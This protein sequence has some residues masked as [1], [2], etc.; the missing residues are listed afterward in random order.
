MLS[1]RFQ[2]RHLAVALAALFTVNAPGMAEEHAFLPKMVRFDNS[3]GVAAT[4]S[5]AGKVDLT[6]P[7]FQSLGTNGRACV[8]CHQPSVGWTVTPQTSGHGSMPRM[9]R[10]PSSAPTMVRR[11]QTPMCPLSRLGA[12][13][14]ACC[15]TKD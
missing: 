3:T 12:S 2:R 5:T 8:T 9:E 10:I 6:G 14:I 13:L 1:R 11:P 15:S 4:F 7:F